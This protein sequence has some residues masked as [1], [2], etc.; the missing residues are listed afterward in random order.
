MLLLPVVVVAVAAVVLVVAVPVLPGGVTSDGGPK[1]T[2][3]VR[4][5]LLCFSIYIN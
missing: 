3:P 5:M 2:S 4:L 1:S